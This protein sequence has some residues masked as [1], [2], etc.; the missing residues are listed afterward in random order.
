MLMFHENYDN[1]VDTELFLQPEFLVEE[2]IK[3]VKKAMRGRINI[4]A[5]TYYK[6]QG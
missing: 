2:N 4:T 6:A 5:K 1:M 3:T